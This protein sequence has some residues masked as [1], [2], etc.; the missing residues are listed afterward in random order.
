MD[1]VGLNFLGVFLRFVD[2]DGVSLLDILMLI[3][4]FIVFFD[5]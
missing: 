3:G 1:D 2:S 5:V 4:R